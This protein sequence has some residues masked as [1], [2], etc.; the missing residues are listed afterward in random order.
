MMREIEAKEPPPVIAADPARQ[1]GPYVPG[2]GAV[3]KT[4]PTVLTAPSAAPAPEL[5]QEAQTRKQ[6]EPKVW[7]NRASIDEIKM[8]KAICGHMGDHVCRNRAAEALRKKLGD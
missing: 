2:T 4:E 6:L 5:T 8:L 7:G 1:G 3:V